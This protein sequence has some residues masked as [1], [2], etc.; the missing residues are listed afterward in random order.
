VQSARAAARAKK[1]VCVVVNEETEEFVAE[2]VKAAKKATASAASSPAIS[3]TK[4]AAT[5]VAKKSTP[6]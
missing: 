1:A 6:R 2:A 5:K 4:T 3:R